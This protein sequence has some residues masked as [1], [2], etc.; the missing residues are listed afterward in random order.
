MSVT[1]NAIAEGWHVTLSEFLGKRTIATL[2]VFDPFHRLEVAY[3]W[4]SLDVSSA[5][6]L[7]GHSGFKAM[8]VKSRTALE[9]DTVVLVAEGGQ[10]VGFIARHPEGCDTVSLHES[11]RGQGLSAPFILAAMQL[12]AASRFAPIDDVAKATRELFNGG[13]YSDAGFASVCA[14]HR[15]A[16][17][18]AVALRR[19][20]PQRVMESSV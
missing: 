20:V 2:P 7:L 8:R 6:S 19:P 13:S 14:A 15:L 18:R 12:R 5:L 11:I 16:V 10:R 9:R 4:Y 1:W 3:Q 17:S